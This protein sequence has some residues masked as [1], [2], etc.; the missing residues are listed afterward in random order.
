M[1]V[2]LFISC[3]LTFYPSLLG[4][5]ICFQRDAGDSIPGCQN[6]GDYVDTNNDYCVRPPPADPTM[7]PT[8]TEVI[9]MAPSV[10]ESSESG[11]AIEQPELLT[12]GNDG[13]FSVYPLSACM[14][15]CDT[16]ED[17]RFSA[18]CCVCFGCRRIVYDSIFIYN[19]ADF[20]L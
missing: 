4:E 20:L 18:F 11:V 14:G 3:R 16:N 13:D 7:S 8:N 17:V 10:G 6:F 2:S 15:D 1:G 12:V 5:L 19:L 9:S